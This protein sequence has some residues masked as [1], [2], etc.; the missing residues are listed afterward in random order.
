MKI[1]INNL[2]CYAKLS[3][4]DEAPKAQML[5]EIKEN[6]YHPKCYISFEA[7]YEGK[8][9]NNIFTYFNS[10]EECFKNLKK[11][12]VYDKKKYKNY[13]YEIIHEG[14][15]IKPYLDA[16]RYYETEEEMETHRPIFL[17]K[18]LNDIIKVFKNEYL[19]N[20]TLD[21]IMVCENS[22]KKYD[23]YKLSFHIIISPK[24]KNL[25]YK[26]NIK[27]G[28]STAY[29]F[30]ISLLNC[31]IEYYKN[32]L[33]VAVYSRD[34]LMRCIGSYKDYKET[35]NLK[36]INTTTYEPIKK[37]TLDIF[38]K[39][40]ITY[41]NTNVE[42]IILNTPLFEQTTSIYKPTTR[43][44]IKTTD[45]ITNEIIYRI[46]KGVPQG[47]FH[48]I[49]NEY[50]SSDFNG[51][52]AK[53][54]GFN[55]GFFTFRPNDTLCPLS[56][57][58]HTKNKNI[59]I[60]ETSDGFLLK[61]FNSDC[62]NYHVKLGHILNEEAYKINCHEIN[63]KYN[64][65]DNNI[66]LFE[67]NIP[68]YNNF[69]DARQHIINW[70]LSNDI[71]TLCIKANMGTGKTEAIKLVCNTGK[72]NRILWVT[73]RITLTEN[74]YGKFKEYNFISYLDINGS[75]F[76]YDKIICQVDSLERLM[77]SNK[78]SFKK[79]DLVI[80]D[81][82]ESVLYHFSSPH[83][84]QK[85]KSARTIF[86]LLQNICKMST[87]I[88]CLDADY[89]IRS[90]QFI[91][92]FGQ[93]ILV[94]N[95]Y[96]TQKKTYVMTQDKKYFLNKI[97]NDLNNGLKICISS[98]SSGIIQGIEEEIIKQ[99]S[100]IKY[101]IYY[102]KTSDKL[103]SELQSVNDMW[104]N[105][106]LIMY[107]PTIESGVDV[108]IPFDKLYGVC[109]G[110]DFTTSQRAFLQMCGRLRNVKNND[111]LCYCNTIIDFNIGSNIYTYDDIFN[112][113]KYSSNM[114]Q[115]PLL[116]Y[117]FKETSDGICECVYDKKNITLFDVINI[118]NFAENINKNNKIFLSVLFRL[119]REKGYDME[120]M[121]INEKDKNEND[122]S[123]SENN[124]SHESDSIGEQT[125]TLT[126]VSS[127]REISIIKWI[128]LISNEQD[129][130]ELLRRQNIGE[131]MEESEKIK[132]ERYIFNSK[133]NI[134][135]YDMYIDDKIKM[136]YESFLTNYY[137]K[138]E[139]TLKNIELQY[140]KKNK[141]SEIY[142]VFHLTDVQYNLLISVKDDLVK[143]FTHDEILSTNG[144][145]FDFVELNNIKKDI[146]D[147]SMYF[148]DENHLRTMMKKDKARRKQDITNN[149]TFLKTIKSFLEY[150]GIELIT[151]N[152]K[153]I[154]INKKRGRT[155]TLKYNL[156][157][158]DILDVK[159]G[160]K[161]RSEF[162]PNIIYAKKNISNTCM[163]DDNK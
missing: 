29:H 146:I 58:E 124:L 90:S 56:G 133:W 127:G 79:Y 159:Y 14:L 102:G 110:G 107:S 106:Q 72:F 115:K 148:R 21:D 55:K 125:L 13:V 52:S 134:N 96:T 139:L 128:T 99:H 53:Y 84:E 108:T 6:K 34:R 83:L 73:P 150:F 5:R 16:E 155:Y 7:F 66:P 93:S 143:R 74:I 19:H 31:D 149:E 24:N 47:F 28:I 130:K 113:F 147:N 12:S 25:L 158:F 68:N 37:I 49:N 67:N 20:I 142:D 82:I 144:I 161:E 129:D 27:Y 160:K 109:Y 23:K 126:S 8:K 123:D 32:V 1:I 154:T 4:E 118:L 95:K 111:I 85:N 151:N 105:Y 51:C 100:D 46:E 132:I 119:L 64:I 11:M 61:C 157:L 81:E 10:W 40:A 42:T 120:L 22:R 91:E 18:C 163:I 117:I 57:I 50:I 17:N 78:M 76:L 70:I 48:Y 97:K 54:I 101:K 112:A 77:G 88:L 75:L 80:I 104:T 122:D 65:I 44:E 60:L 140:Y 63:V 156:V 141:Q 59:Y 71:K 86:E 138:K 41:E 92:H 33:D 43:S 38:L 39:F 35:E 9:I 131:K 2:A 145:T 135:M 26:T 98:M 62:K 136:E 87:K 89:N 30:Y 152:E 153:K 3:N 162:Y 103:K 15:L 94:Y 114:T 45:Y 137:N 69:Q 116:K 121:D 36:Q